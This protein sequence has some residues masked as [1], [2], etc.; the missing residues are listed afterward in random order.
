MSV[1]PAMALQPTK[2]DHRRRANWGHH[3][4][5]GC[6]DEGVELLVSDGTRFASVST[7]FPFL[8]KGFPPGIAR[9]LSEVV[10]T[11]RSFG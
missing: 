1:T 2:R 7:K 11:S 6:F 4:L 8:V 5:I 9:C 10:R 3:Q